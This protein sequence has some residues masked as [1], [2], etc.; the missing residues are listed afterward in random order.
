MML[1]DLQDSVKLNEGPAGLQLTLHKGFHKMD[2]NLHDTFLSKLTIQ[3]QLC[4]LLQQ[5]ATMLAAH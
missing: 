3:I 2:V 5:A 1:L 4:S